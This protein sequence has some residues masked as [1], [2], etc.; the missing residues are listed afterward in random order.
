MSLPHY[1]VTKLRYYLWVWQYKTEKHAD[2]LYELCS[3]A[4]VNHRLKS[5]HISMELAI[6]LYTV[7]IQSILRHLYDEYRIAFHCRNNDYKFIGFMPKIVN[8][9]SRWILSIS[10]YH[11]KC[12]IHMQTDKVYKKYRQALH[13]IYENDYACR[14]FTGPVEIDVK[15]WQTCRCANLTFDPEIKRLVKRKYHSIKHEELELKRRTLYTYS[16]YVIL[17]PKESKKLEKQ[18]FKPKPVVKNQKR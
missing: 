15:K 3:L 12:W 11:N 13:R 7:K 17:A 9:F 8:M 10:F 1:A 4:V 14:H 16:A 18:K 2:S 6:K 5:N